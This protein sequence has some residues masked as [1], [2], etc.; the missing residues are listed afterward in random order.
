M[1]KINISKLT[2]KPITKKL[3]VEDN[4][5]NKEI[6]EM[7]QKLI[8]WGIHLTSRFQDKDNYFVVRFENG[9]DLFAFVI[10]YSGVKIRIEEGNLND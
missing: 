3:I 5:S 6:N 1:K 8:D 4:L 2:K 9:I 7:E 10:M